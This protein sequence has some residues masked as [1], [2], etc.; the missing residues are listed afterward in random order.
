MTA[1]RTGERGWRRTLGG[2]ARRRRHGRHDHPARRLGDALRGAVPGLRRGARAGE[3]VA[4]VRRAATAAASCRGSTRC[5]CSRRAWCCAGAW[6]ARARGDPR[7]LLPAT[8]AAALLGVGFLGAQLAIWRAMLARG[9][10]PSS[11]VY[12]SVFYAL[13]GF[14]AL[15]V[16]GGV[17]ALAA[18]GDPRARGTPRRPNAAARAAAHG[19]LLGLRRDRLGRDVPGGLLAVSA[20]GES[21]RAFVGCRLLGAALA[22]RASR[23]SRARPA[24][25]LPIAGPM[26]LGGRTHLGRKP[27]PRRRG[28]H[29]LLPSLPRHRRRRQRSVGAGIAPLAARSAPRDLQVRLGGRRPAA[30]RRR[31]RAHHQGRPA[32]HRD[33]GLGRAGRRARRPR[34]STP[35]RSRRAG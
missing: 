7:A 17:V 12:G 31:L 11:G 14:H 10:F 24:S 22:A 1:A 19:A 21:D 8:V 32:R 28:L 6:R 33:A 20:R 3:R 27:A 29:P 16:A 15:H 2:G 18:A 25:P 9:L 35:R 30:D 26:T 13:T 5:C 4:A 34:S 23:A